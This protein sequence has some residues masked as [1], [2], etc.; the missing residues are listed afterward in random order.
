MG[1]T[2]KIVE[3]KPEA[4]P[5]KAKKG[6]AAAKDAKGKDATKGSEEVSNFRVSMDSALRESVRK[7]L[8]IRHRQS[9][10]AAWKKRFCSKN[11]CLL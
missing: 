2:A 10:F 3:A 11:T 6:K 1:E 5:A 4:K 8:L 7:T 9:G